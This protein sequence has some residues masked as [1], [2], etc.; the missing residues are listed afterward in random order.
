[1]V[2]GESHGAVYWLSDGRARGI[3]VGYN[4]WAIAAS[5]DGSIIVGQ[6][7]D[8]QG[9]FR[10]ENG[11]TEF[12]GGFDV[13]DITPDGRVIATG[14]GLWRADTGVTPIGMYPLGISDDGLLAIGRLGLNRP[15]LWTDATGAVELQPFLIGLGFD[16]SG[17]TLTEITAISGNGM[18][19]AGRGIPPNHSMSGA[20]FA[21]I[22][23]P[24]TYV[25][26]A[27]AV[28]GVGLL[29]WQL[30]RLRAV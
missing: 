1:V 14:G 25:L 21:S 12:L 20:W 4:S 24:S 18:M 6:A 26:A 22:P 16:L 13:E 3:G 28:A 19:L 27:F 5:R 23:E 2:V 30:M 11:R 29:I 15:A 9:A 8:L 17:W 7:A 10:W